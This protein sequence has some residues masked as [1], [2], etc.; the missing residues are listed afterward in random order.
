MTISPAASGN[1]HSGPLA[2]HHR[3]P[4]PQLCSTGLSCPEDIDATFPRRRPSP[5]SSGPSGLRQIHP[6]AHPQP[7]ERPHR[8]GADR[9]PGPHRR[10]GHL[11]PRTWSSPNC[12]RRWAWSSSGPTPFPCPFT[13]T[14]STGPASMASLR[15]PNWM[16]SWSA[17]WTAVEMWDEV[18]DRL[19]TSALSLT[20]E[21]QQRLCI[22]RLLAVEPE[23]L[24]WTSPARPWTPWPPCAS[25]S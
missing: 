20:E 4:A 15:K 22:A 5:P 14:W 12:A 23:I 11:R 18:K 24:L 8:G 16:R 1:D 2:G 17:P 3:A 9:R 19:K 7:H 25:K 21:Q 13:T 10:P 6:A